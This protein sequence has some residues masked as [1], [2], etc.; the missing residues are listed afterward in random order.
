ME[1]HRKRGPYTE[2][3]RILQRQKKELLKELSDQTIR[4]PLR[5]FEESWKKWQET[6]GMMRDRYRGPAKPRKKK[7][8]RKRIL[9]I[10]DLHIPFHDPEMVA[11]MLAKEAGNVDLAICIGD[12]GDAYSHSGLRSMRM[13]PIRMNGLK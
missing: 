10:P 13:F 2:N 6:I 3:S 9:V 12:I 11:A 5:T 1:C 4:Q 8:N 7:S